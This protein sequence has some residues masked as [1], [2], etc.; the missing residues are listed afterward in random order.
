MVQYSL[1]IYIYIRIIY[2]Y[3]YYIYLLIKRRI[4]YA[5][6]AGKN[7]EGG[8]QLIWKTYCAVDVNV[9]NTRYT[10]TE[11][12]F[13]RINYR[14]INCTVRDIHEGDAYLLYICITCVF[15]CTYSTHL[16]SIY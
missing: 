9:L 6:Q 8:I 4:I 7:L 14:F 13:H 16:Y 15:T 2:I 1:H 5:H 12:N 3:I 10:H 11:Y